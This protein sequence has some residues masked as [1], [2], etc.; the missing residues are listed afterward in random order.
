MTT[1][2]LVPVLLLGVFCFCQITRLHSKSSRSSESRLVWLRPTLDGEP[3]RA[4]DPAGL[5]LAPVFWAGSTR[6]V[7]V[8]SGT[9]TSEE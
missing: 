5:G 8:T 3:S 2:S 6:W 9:P 1:F 7:G 4:S